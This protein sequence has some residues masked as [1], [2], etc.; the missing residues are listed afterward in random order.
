MSNIEISQSEQFKIKDLSIVTKAGKFNLGSVF[1]ELNI[2]DTMLMPCMSGNISIRDAVG[3][4]QKL[5]FDGRHKE[6]VIFIR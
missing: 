2:F 1:E 6:N 3:L 4:S 5:Y